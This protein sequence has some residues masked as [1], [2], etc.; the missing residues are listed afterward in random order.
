M[1]RLVATTTGEPMALAASAVS[2]F[3]EGSAVGVP[4][5]LALLAELPIQWSE[6]GREPVGL[7]PLHGELL[8][9]AGQALSQSEQLQSAAAPILAALEVWVSAGGLRAELL[10]AAGLLGPLAPLLPTL[11]NP[12]PAASLFTVLA[13][14]LLERLEMLGDMEPTRLAASAAAEF[15]AALV[16]QLAA[17]EQTVALVSR[18]TD[19][20][21]I[22]LAVANLMAALAELESSFGLAEAMSGAYVPSLLSE[23]ANS[24]HR[25]ALAL[26]GHPD[27]AVGESALGYWSAI[28]RLANSA[29][30]N[31]G[32]PQL[33]PLFEQLLPAV[34]G[35]ALPYPADSEPTRGTDEWPDGSTID[36]GAWTRRRRVGAGCVADC[37]GVLGPARVLEILASACGSGAG[38]PN[39][40]Q[41]EAS[42]HA[43]QSA[44]AELL[45][46]RS[47]L[48]RKQNL[49]ASVQPEL[50]LALET[51]LGPLLLF[52]SENS[53]G[54]NAA[55]HPL[56]RAA[57]LGVATAYSDWLCHQPEALAAALNFAAQALVSPAVGAA[58][59]LAPNAASFIG[60][61]S[62]EAAMQVLRLPAELGIDMLLQ[63]LPT[64][65]MAAGGTERAAGPLLEAL[66][67][68]I[69]AAHFAAGDDAAASVNSWAHSLAAPIH[70]RLATAETGAEAAAAVCLLG[71]V[72]HGSHASK[73]P[74]DSSS[75]ADKGLVVLMLEALWPT[76]E[77]V[78]ANLSGAD[79]DDV[80]EPLAATLGTAVRAAGISAAES[81]LPAVSSLLAAASPTS[82]SWLEL[83]ATIVE[84]YGSATVLQKREPRRE[85]A[86]TNEALREGLVQLGGAR[87]GA[88]LEGGAAVDPA[89]AAG[90][91][92]LGLR[93][94]LFCP[95]ALARPTP[96]VG[97]GLIEVAL[98]CLAHEHRSTARAAAM[99]LQGSLRVDTMERLPFLADWLR[100]ANTGR[101]AVASA[102][103]AAVESPVAD[104]ASTRLAAAFASCLVA[105]RAVSAL[106]AEAFA[107]DTTAVGAHVGIA[108]S[109]DH[110]EAV[111]E[112]A[113]VSQTAVDDAAAALVTA[114]RA[115]RRLR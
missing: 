66:S 84:V 18:R 100:S 75:R 79:D 92:E 2:I 47:G 26:V 29:A 65:L 46:R 6:A 95:E 28:P 99:F 80:S 27:P 96:A 30:G 31:Q 54:Q 62:R 24:S 108:P 42:L 45:P 58:R 68:L 38:S 94:V 7:W 112:A 23:G 103:A 1:C 61:I 76:I 104:L 41:L 34:V 14:S 13:E 15:A 12:V 56:C 110:L 37:C 101:R 74:A 77:S 97:Q 114:L 57:T 52:D 82:P 83:C 50:A 89:A 19:D 105:A 67:R 106:V 64:A 86:V 73:S 21:G 20:E 78:V 51:I 98:G 33:V 35:G 107:E 81:L 55:A 53:D 60:K 70:D 88:A 113:A 9:L 71:R 63:M 85:G 43:L 91:L 90:I 59:T 10:H 87:I 39:W 17:M 69:S 72:L 49:A 109:P 36:E 25:I 44:S 102:L 22:C 40:R 93:C 48:L 111:W 11:C 4:G 115:G 5:L 32:E 3:G 16:P 8:Q